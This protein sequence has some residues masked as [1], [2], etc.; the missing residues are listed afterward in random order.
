MERKRLM[1]AFVPFIVFVLLA[2]IFPG[3]YLHKTLREKSIEAGLDELEKLNVPN[4]PRA[5][6]CNMVVL[7]VYM[8]GGEDA[9]E[10]EELLQRFHINVRVSREDKWFLSMVGRLRIEQLDDFMK[11]SERDGWIAVYYNETE[12]CA[13]WISN[14]EIENRIILAHLD[15]L[16]PESRDVLLRV[17]RRNRRDMKKTRESMEKWADLTIFVH[18]GGEATPD[19]FH[20]LS[21]LLATLGILVGFGS[22]LAI[23][24]RKEERNR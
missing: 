10:L 19:D 17:V 6:P 9:E 18:S 24:S 3:V 12:T 5:G 21:V 4:A 13:E 1:R 11:E 15:Q 8:N 22:I 16:S 23:I 14:D 2:L 7:Y 20:Q